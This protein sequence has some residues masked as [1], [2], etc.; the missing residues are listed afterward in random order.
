M[1]GMSGAEL[2]NLCNEAALIAGR[3]GKTRIDQR[4]F[5]A[6][7]D[8]VRLGLKREE[9][10]SEEQKK[11]TAYHEAGHALCALLEPKAD[12][13]ER[14][15]IVS[16]GNALGVTLF[17]PDEDRLATISE[18]ELRAQLVVA[19]GG[20]AADK[21]AF[22]ES[23]SGAHADIKQATRIARLMVTQFGMSERLGPVHF[24]QGEEHVFLGKEI[25]EGRDFSEGTARIID[26]EIQRLVGEGLNRA[27]EL[28]QAH[29]KD[30]DRIAEALLLH[31]ELDREEVGLVMK[32]VPLAELRKPPAPPAAP[33][34]EPAA[35]PSP[36]PEPKPGL[37]FGGA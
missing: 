12:K 28:L 17:Q 5:D 26:E 20:R 6:A 18:A 30:L 37:A 1:I 23:R 19:M 31:E 11:Q 3:E 36:Q 33:T 34:P 32:G 16:R 27:Q 10:F 4:D 13:I 21:L 7:G 25:H 2:R 14:V 8:R 35:E 9:Q 15:S 29:R 22:G 24:R